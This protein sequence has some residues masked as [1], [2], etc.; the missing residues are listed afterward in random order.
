MTRHWSDAPPAS[1][2][3]FDH[4]EPRLAGKR[5]QPAARIDRIEA[6]RHAVLDVAADRL[7]VAAAHVGDDVAMAGG[8][9]D[10]PPRGARIGMAPGRPGGAGADEVARL[11]GIF[12]GRVQREGQAAAPVLVIVERGEVAAV[13]AVARE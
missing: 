9:V 8:V 2:A 4:Y 10:A 11:G 7:D 6:H 3:L 5:G 13:T 1:N 12:V